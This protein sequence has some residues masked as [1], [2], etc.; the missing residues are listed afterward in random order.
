MG[1]RGA[2]KHVAHGLSRHVFITKYKLTPHK[3][4]QVQV[5]YMLYH[6]EPFHPGGIIYR[7][8]VLFDVSLVLV[9]W[10]HFRSCPCI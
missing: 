7:M 5:L 8:Y 1:S 4:V 3:K 9:S 10:Y 6:T 2:T